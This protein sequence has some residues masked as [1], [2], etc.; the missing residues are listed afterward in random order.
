MA[1]RATA[2]DELSNALSGDAEPWLDVSRDSLP[3]VLPPRRALE[4]VIE[5][6]FRHIDAEIPL[7]DRQRCIEAINQC[8]GGEAERVD[9]AWKVIFNYIMILCFQGRYMP[10]ERST[11]DIDFFLTKEFD[12]PYLE[13]LRGA[14]AC[15]SLFTEPSFTN[16]QALVALVRI[17][18]LLVLVY[19]GCN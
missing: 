14:C 7:L 9:P 1:Q 8:Y 12:L 5:P 16:V 13:D 2:H 6:Y 15:L 19:K 3:L 17:S 18:L 10:L 11:K 4:A